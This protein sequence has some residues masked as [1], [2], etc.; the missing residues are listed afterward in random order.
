MIGADIPTTHRI[1]DPSLGG[2][3]LLDLY[4]V[5]SE[6]I[7]LQMLISHALNF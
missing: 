1:L 7:Y 2:G 3:A 5:K 4:V 6:L